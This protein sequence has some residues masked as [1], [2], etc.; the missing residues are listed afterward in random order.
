MEKW[1]WAKE[2]IAGMTVCEWREWTGR[3]MKIFVDFGAHIKMRHTVGEEQNEN[4]RSLL[5]C[6]TTTWTI[7]YRENNFVAWKTSFQLDEFVVATLHKWTPF[8]VFKDGKMYPSASRIH[9][10]G[11]NFA[12]PTMRN[13]C[14]CVVQNAWA[15]KWWPQTVFLEQNDPLPRDFV[16][17]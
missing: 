14:V 8:S 11:F 12:L 5:Q 4:G 17:I 2:M 13:P 10:S 15:L 9:G 16:C 1:N 3:E 7:I 6:P